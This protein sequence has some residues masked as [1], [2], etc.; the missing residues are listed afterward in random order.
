MN[1]TTT[2]ILSLLSWKAG[3]FFIVLSL[4]L[5]AVS[6]IFIIDNDAVGNYLDYRSGY[7][8]QWNLGEAREDY[9][10]GLLTIEDLSAIGKEHARC[11]QNYG[12]SVHN[13]RIILDAPQKTTSW[14]PAAVHESM[15]W[16]ESKTNRDLL[17]EYL[18]SGIAPEVTPPQRPVRSHVTALENGITLSR[19]TIEELPVFV[20][21]SPER[22]DQFYEENR[23]AVI[24]DFLYGSYDPSQAI[25]DAINEGR[26]NDG[27]ATVLVSTRLPGDGALIGQGESRRVLLSHDRLWYAY[28]E[29]L[30]DTISFETGFPLVKGDT[31]HKIRFIFLEEASND[32]REQMNLQEDSEE[33]IYYY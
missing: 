29:V 23:F 27:Y 14:V 21:V 8:E 9:E 31:Y 1:R 3:L 18:L 15:N 33:K 22:G 30:A 5:P 13:T 24:P 4:L 16:L 19:L 25:V 6:G 2:G 17:H 11:D 28:R 12:I 10:E 32:Y 26:N 20:G 7:V